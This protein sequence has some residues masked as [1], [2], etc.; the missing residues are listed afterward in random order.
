MELNGF[1]NR[2]REIR[3]SLERKIFFAAIL[4]EALKGEGEKPI[5]VGGT[6]VEFYTL[7][8][9][10]TLDLDLVCV[11]REKLN[12]L[13]E[14]LGFKK[15]GRHWY[16]EELD[17]AVESPGS[18]L[19]GSIERLTKIEVGGLTA[20]VIGIEDIIADRLRAYV[21]WKSDDDGRWAR[22]MMV[23]HRDK[24]DW[25]YLEEKSRSDGTREALEQ[26][27]TEVE[28]SGR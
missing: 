21:H 8:G 26:M 27:R 2:A 15:Y 1:L 18:V 6:A 4:V 10:S 12:V 23:L 9:Y 19:S 16:S 14:K 17:L 3:D 22:R 11:K 25:D 13:L 24:I 5:I 28:E 20:Y 7:G